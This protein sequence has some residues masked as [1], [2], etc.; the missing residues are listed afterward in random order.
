MATAKSD[1][2]HV[3]LSTEVLD[4][5][6][7]KRDELAASIA[8]LGPTSALAL[9]NPG[10]A[11]QVTVVATTYS[12]YKGAVAKAGAS[13]KQHATDVEAAVGARVLSNKALRL[14][15]SLLEN[16]ATT[17]AQV[18]LVGM[19]AYTGKPA[20]PPLV[21]P[22][23]DVKLGQKGS[24]KA[25]AAAHET[26]STRYSYSAQSTANPIGNSSTWTDLVGGG[27]TRKLAGPSGTSLWV[28]FA[29]RRGQLLSDWSTPILVT[30]P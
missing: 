10:I 19:D 23:V 29:L 27:K 16:A 2:V 26:G 20:E 4:D 7:T 12:A 17:P 3:A 11:S 14:L 13:G 9:A 18:N 21:A 5:D 1:I 6:E 30:F 24:G 15:A 25:T 22:L 28:R 8:A